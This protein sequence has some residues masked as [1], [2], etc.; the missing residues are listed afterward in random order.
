MVA[1]PVPVVVDVQAQG[2]RLLRGDVRPGRP[3]EGGELQRPQVTHQ[4]AV[5]PRRPEELDPV[6]VA[7]VA[8][9]EAEAAAAGRRGRRTLDERL[10]RGQVGV[11][12]TV[13]GLVVPVLRVLGVDGVARLAARLLRVRA[14][15]VQG[16][17]VVLTD[18]DPV[19]EVL[20]VGLGVVDAA[21]GTA[22]HERER[23]AVGLA[24]VV[25]DQG[26]RGVVGD[27]GVERGRRSRAAVTVD[28]DLAVGDVPVLPHAVGHGLLVGVVAR[29]EEQ[30]GIASA[31]R[32]VVDVEAQVRRLT[33]R[34]LAAG[35]AGEGRV[36][37]PRDVRQRGAVVVGRPV[38]L[39]LDRGLPDPDPVAPGAVRRAVGTVHVVL[40]GIEVLPRGGV[41]VG[42]LDP[43]ARVLHLG[44][45]AGLGGHGTWSTEGG[46]DQ[47]AGG[48]HAEATPMECLHGISWEIIRAPRTN[49]SWAAGSDA[50]ENPRDAVLPRPRTVPAAGG[51]YP[52]YGCL[53]R[54]QPGNPPSASH[55]PVASAGDRAPPP[56]P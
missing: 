50:Q 5:V 12:R 10:L 3:L 21:P 28:A 46:D 35:A 32:V 2:G 48:K 52:R 18:D 8:Q 26:R 9:R 41:L 37:E 6:R 27:V 36:L 47:G 23:A 20:T 24:A 53:V 51:P 39:G 16:V 14:E 56:S 42:L 30:A 38:E 1:L 34:A 43:G 13:V 49:P 15:V 7:V 29:E 17:V 22:V 45:G 44:R 4:R 25:V 19:D 54:L 40:L 55:A 31:V 11:R 33:V